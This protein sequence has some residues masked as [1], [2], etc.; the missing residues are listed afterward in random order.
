[1]GDTARALLKRERS[2]MPRSGA[3]WLISLTALLACAIFVVHHEAETADE[4]IT[5]A[6]LSDE[7]KAKVDADRTA[8]EVAAAEAKAKAEVALEIMKKATQNAL[9]IEPHLSIATIGLP[10]PAETATAVK[11][12]PPAPKKVKPAEKPQHEKPFS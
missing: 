8:R 6:W 9:G 7:V 10:A 12:V 3:V 1:M 2:S 4:V 11:Q 5:Q